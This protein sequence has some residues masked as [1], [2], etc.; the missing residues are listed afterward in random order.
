MRKKNNSINNEFYSEINWR[1]D[2]NKSDMNENSNCC[3]NEENWNNKEDSWNDNDKN[4]K[5]EENWFINWNDKDDNGWNNFFNKIKTN[6][7]NL[8]HKRKRNNDNIS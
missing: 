2:Y 7:M 4:K 3:I 1:D 5:E 8:N 6:T